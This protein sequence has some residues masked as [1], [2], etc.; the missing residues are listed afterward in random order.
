MSELRR[1]PD[2]EL[3]V[4]QVLWTLPSPSERSRIEEALKET[5]P[6]APTTVLTLLGR[7][8]ERGFVRI[9]KYGRTARYVPLVSRK[10]YQRTQSRRF[11]E[12]LFGG[13]ISAFASALCEGGLD[14]EDLKELK[15]MLERDTL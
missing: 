8:A 4:M 1:L 14:P 12:K 3:E 2:T 13:N 6:M 5:H 9:E 10:D 15:D 7:L 11:V